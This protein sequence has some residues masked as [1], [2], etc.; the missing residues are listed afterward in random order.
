MNG[1]DGDLNGDDEGEE[2]RSLQDPKITALQEQSVRKVVETLSDFNNVL[3]EI[4]NESDREV[5][6]MAVPHDPV[7][8]AYR[9]WK[10]RSAPVGMTVAYPRDTK[11][12]TAIYPKVPPIGF[13][14][15]RTDSIPIAKIH[16]RQTEGRSSSLIRI[17]CGE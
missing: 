17:T 8:K 10:E 3:W 1:I 11:K 9:G 5:Q 6:R 15:R 16:P 7:D 12:T 14:L 2:I 13:R 4:S